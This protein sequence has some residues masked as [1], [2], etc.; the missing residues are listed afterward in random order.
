MT[1]FLWKS[2]QQQVAMQTILQGA[3]PATPLWFVSRSHHSLC[4]TFILLRKLISKQVLGEQVL[5]PDNVKEW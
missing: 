2:A 3:H 1:D 5:G 4:V